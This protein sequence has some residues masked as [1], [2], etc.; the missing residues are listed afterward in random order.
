MRNTTQGKPCFHYRDG[1]AVHAN[2]NCAIRE[3]PVLNFKMYVL[4]LSLL[5]V[6]AQMSSPVSLYQTL[7]WSEESMICRAV[8]RSENPGGLVVLGGRMCPPGGDRVN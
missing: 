5:N 8:A 4:L 7:Q 3:L 1:F 2:G 6:S